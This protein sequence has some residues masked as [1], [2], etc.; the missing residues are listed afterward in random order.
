MTQNPQERREYYC[1][2]RHTFEEVLD[3]ERCFELFMRDEMYK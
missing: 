3:C 2:G 1:G